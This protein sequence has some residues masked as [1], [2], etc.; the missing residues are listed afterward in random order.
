MS[1]KQSDTGQIAETGNEGSVSKS[2]DVAV[3]GDN[4]M[5]GDFD[6]DLPVEIYRYKVVYPGGVYVR[7]SPSVDSERT[8]EILEFGEVFQASKSLVLD[9]INY[10]KLAS[11]N[12]WVFG[13]IGDTEVL[14]LMEVNRVPARFL[15]RGSDRKS[16]SVNGGTSV[17]PCSSSPPSSP[18]LSSS[19]TV[20]APSS[21]AETSTSATSSSSSGA[22]SSSSTS[23]SSPNRNTT[24]P[25]SSSTNTAT[26][27]TV[28]TSTLQSTI[29]S[30]QRL[31]V[32]RAQQEKEKLFQTV[33]SENR[34]WRELRARCGEC[35]NFDDFLVLS[36][37]LDT[38]PP[39][40]PEPGPARSAWMAESSRH[41]EQVRNVISII[42]SVTKQCAE[43]VTDM[44]GLESSLWVL[45]H[46]GSRILHAMTLAVDAA[47]ARFELLSRNR[48]TELLYI[49]FEVAS[50]TKV[51]CAELSKLLDILPEDL[52]NYLQRW[53]IIKSYDTAAT[54]DSPERA[55]SSPEHK[56]P[57]SPVKRTPV[58]EKVK[59]S[60]GLPSWLCVQ[61]PISFLPDC[62]TTY[63]NGKVSPV[64]Q[65]MRGKMNNTS[66]PDGG[67]YGGYGGYGGGG[68]GRGNNMLDDDDSD[69]DQDGI[70]LGQGTGNRYGFW[71]E[72]ERQMK[73][74]ADPDIMKAG[75]I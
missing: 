6:D 69:D 50:L 39:P 9:G 58:A 56:N 55:P 57:Q 43:G 30:R 72:V 44:A 26:S 24:Y 16:S 20:S 37:G 60:W 1:R 25:S 12:G 71:K 52:R 8:G 41:D 64:R 65:Q 4:S 70:E 75:L 36:S 46:M 68:R 33:R 22:S 23:P 63:M 53:V 73:R 13:S 67:G 74:I 35:T 14:E 59:A 18:R 38:V 51:H 3:S 40:L 28:F 19:S 29:T 49:V 31:T 10:A 45:V 7:V 27:A 61:D 21:L 54:I 62:R 34:R 66:S 48:Q 15:K 47:N 17:T 5:K 2:V 42:A 11:G 32:T